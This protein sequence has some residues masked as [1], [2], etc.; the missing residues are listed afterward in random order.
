MFNSVSPANFILKL[1]PLEVKTLIHHILVFAFTAFMVASFFIAFIA[2][3]AAGFFIAFMVFIAFMGAMAG[4][5]KWELRLTRVH[6]KLRTN[7][8]I[9][10][11]IHFVVMYIY[12]ALA[13]QAR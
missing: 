6:E 12:N 13:R 8:T 10:T 7:E 9:D 2:F 1:C 11:N 5:R 4:E 3:M